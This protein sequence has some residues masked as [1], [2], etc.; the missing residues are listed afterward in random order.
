MQ[1]KLI[2]E[3][4][5][6]YIACRGVYYPVEVHIPKWPNNFEGLSKQQVILI[7]LSIMTI[8]YKNALYIGID[9]T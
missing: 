6:R 5:V 4:C 8:S 3:A 7:A 1:A 2:L 9:L